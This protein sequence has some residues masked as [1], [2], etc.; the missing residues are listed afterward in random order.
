MKELEASFRAQGIMTFGH[1]S[2]RIRCF[3]HVINLVVR[4]ILDSLPQAAH[5]YHAAMIAQDLVLDDQTEEYLSALE[6][7]PVDKCRSLVGAMRISD[8]RRQGLQEAIR[9]GN[10]HGLFIDSLGESIQVPGLQLLRDSETRW[11]STYNMLRRFIQL[12]SA[13]V[14]YGLRHPSVNVPLLSRKQ[15]EVLEDICSVLSILHN[16]QELLS[17][18]RTPT[19]ALALP[20]YETLLVTLSQIR[21]TFPELGHAITRGIDKLKGYIS[22]TH[23]IPLYALAMAVNPCFKLE[24]INHQW[25]EPA[26]EQ[27]YAAVRAQMLRHRQEQLNNTVFNVRTQAEAAARALGSGYA[28]VLTGGMSIT[29]ASNRIN[30]PAHN[31]YVVDSIEM[32][33]TV[34]PTSHPPPTNPMA[35]V[36]SELARWIA[37]GT[38]NVQDMG[39]I[40][41]VQ[42]W[43]LRCNEFPLL[44]RVAMDV[45]PAQASSVS[46]ERAFSSS[47]L[48]CTR[49]R[50]SISA[51]NLERLQVLKHSLH[52]RPTSTGQAA[53]SLDF[54]T[55]ITGEDDTSDSDS[56]REPEF[57]EGFET[58]QA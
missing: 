9:D 53:G 1:E 5:H 37:Q 23:S 56:E 18:E 41:L 4:A 55:H 7:K 28:R 38:L 17:A 6:S 50:N 49:E 30:N 57:D 27:A 3:P 36:E 25:E 14:H 15:A 31:P 44:Y 47:K 46:S 54:M 11:W 16:A 2:N 20:V 45:L 40:E 42:F 10:F 33:P 8:S 32:P 13:I 26:R 19:V 52:R 29:R 48:T 24:W 51:E 34:T 35:E 39:T 12:N 58:D 22:K 21:A 43:M